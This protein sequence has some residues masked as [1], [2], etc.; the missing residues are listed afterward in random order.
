MRFSP[1]MRRLS[2]LVARPIA[3]R[4]L[5]N[6]AAGILENTSS[7]F[8]AALERGY[9]IEC[10]LQ[11]TKDGEAVVFHDRTLD[12]MMAATGRVDGHTAAELMSLPFKVSQDRVQTLVEFLQQVDGRVPLVIEIKS[13]WNGD[14]RLTMRA[15]KILENYPG[16]YCLMSFDPYVIE[17]V[18]RESPATIRGIVADRTIDDDYRELTVSQRLEMRYFTHLART[19]PDF[20]SFYWR[21][22]PWAPVNQFRQAGCPVL[23]WT[24][25]S[26]EV[27]SLARRYCDQITF[28][29]F[30]P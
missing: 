28:E 26:P 3:H 21:G 13:R 9:G 15:L 29:R 18:R 30:F 17:V 23:S 16:P 4:G 22:L 25:R 20:I 6:E 11:I 8:A 27:A 7:A 1:D 19:R 24:V 2:W 12:R 10:D 5:H 14:E